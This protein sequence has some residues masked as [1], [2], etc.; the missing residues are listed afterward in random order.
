MKA[1][2]NN[3]IKPNII[4]IIILLLVDLS[5]YMEQKYN[6]NKEKTNKK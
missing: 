3:T 4:L 2:N 6:Q 5:L 1:N